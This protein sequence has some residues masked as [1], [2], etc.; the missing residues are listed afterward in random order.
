MSARK[1]AFA[2]VVAGA[3]AAIGMA[4]AADAA[5]LQKVTVKVTNK[6][7]FTATVCVTDNLGGGCRDIGRGRSQLFRVE[8]G[9]GTPVNVRVLARNGGSDDISV[10]TG[11]TSLTFETRGDRTRPTVKLTSRR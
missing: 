8:P 5:A 2:A 9:R 4:P 11:R 3:A 7:S 6:A 10:V 1:L